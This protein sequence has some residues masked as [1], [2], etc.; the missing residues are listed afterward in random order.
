MNAERTH[1]LEV[2]GH[3]IGIVEA[4]ELQVGK[5]GARHWS[6]HARRPVAVLVF[7]GSV[8]TRLE[9]QPSEPAAE[10]F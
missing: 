4:C 7:H 8:T 3:R 2:A 5:S 9:L 1:W 6:M 10:A